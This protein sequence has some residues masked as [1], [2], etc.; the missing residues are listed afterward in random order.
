MNISLDR[1]REMCM[2]D[3]A[4]AKEEEGRKKNCVTF[5]SPINFETIVYHQFNLMVVYVYVYIFPLLHSM[6]VLLSISM[7]PLIARYLLSQV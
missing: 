6:C 2:N 5:D 1:V 4:L 7:L 3:N